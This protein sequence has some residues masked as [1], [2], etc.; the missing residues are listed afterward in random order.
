[1]TRP[2]PLATRTILE[3]VVTMRKVFAVALCAAVVACGGDS[4]TATSAGIAGT[5][6]LATVNGGPLPFTFQAAE[7]KLELLSDQ[8][9]LTA[10]GTFTESTVVRVTDEGVVTTRTFPDAGTYIVDAGLASLTFGDGS[11]GTYTVGNN[12]LTG[13]ELGLTVVYTK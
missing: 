12:R 2:Q 4:A 9:I 5:Y 10:A 1:M 11:I 13:T 6:T 8:L 7:P 3:C